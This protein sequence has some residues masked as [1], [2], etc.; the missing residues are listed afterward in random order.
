MGWYGLSRVLRVGMGWR[1]NF[2]IQSDTIRFIF[3]T[4]EK[5][6]VVVVVGS[7]DY[8]I[9]GN[10]L[11]QS[12]TIRFIFFTFEK[13]AVVVVVGSRDYNIR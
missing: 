6:A 7:R 10:F 4:F 2:L 8:N 11:I 13:F 12:D 5:F 9:R 1:G 3:F